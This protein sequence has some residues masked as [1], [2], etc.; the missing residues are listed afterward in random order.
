MMKRIRGCRV[1]ESGLVTI[2]VPPDVGDKA[3]RALRRLGRYEAA[4]LWCGYGYDKYSRRAEHEHFAHRCPDAPEELREHAKR[5]L[6]LGDEVG[7]DESAEE[8]DGDAETR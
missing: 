1:P 8:K 2:D 3:E 4:C 6:L 5:R 7:H